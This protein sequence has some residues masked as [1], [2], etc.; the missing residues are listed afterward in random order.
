MDETDEASIRARVGRIEDAV[1]E[2]LTEAK[3]KGESPVHAAHRVVAN[4]LASQRA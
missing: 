3:A 1:F 4:R 2:I